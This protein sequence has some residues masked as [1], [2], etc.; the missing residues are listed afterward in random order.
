[1]N[2]DRLLTA[3]RLGFD[4][5]AL[6]GLLT[7]PKFSASSY[8]LVSDLKKQG[9]APHTVVDVGANVGQFAVSAGMQFPDAIIHCFEPIPE[10]AGELRKNT[11]GLSEVTIYNAAV[12]SANG[13][14][15]F[16]VNSHSHSSSAL[17]LAS[18]HKEAFP[19][20]EVERM[21]SV[22]VTTLDSALQDSEL[23]SPC[24][25]KLDVQGFEADVIAGAE[26]VLSKSDFVVM[27]ASLKP[28]YEGEKLFLELVDIMRNAGYEFL[29]P[30]G[31]LAD[32][33]T[34]EILQIDVLFGRGSNSN[35]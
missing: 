32:P 14:L 29:R 19:A 20:A 1:M 16:N 23:R 27:E 18:S 35:R 11:A 21:I 30:I 24:L 12:G 2:V 25:I 9:I 33:K 22:P 26:E 31:S 8:T 4:L 3:I 17:E 7:W 6:R 28:M 5:Q 34:R 13:T 15:S 10:C